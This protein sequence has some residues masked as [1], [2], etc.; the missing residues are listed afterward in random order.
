MDLNVSNTN[1]MISSTTPTRNSLDRIDI[2]VDV[3]PHFGRRQSTWTKLHSALD[4]CC[5]PEAQVDSFGFLER[6]VNAFVRGVGHLFSLG[7]RNHL[8]LSNNGVVDCWRG[9]QIDYMLTKGSRQASVGIETCLIQFPWVGRLQPD[10]SPQRMDRY[11][12]TAAKGCRNI[13]HLQPKKAHRIATVRLTISLSTFLCGLWS[14]LGLLPLF[15]WF[16]WLYV[17]GTI[18][19]DCKQLFR[20]TL[21]PFRL[22]I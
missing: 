20:L 2:S 9:I 16:R 22:G 19:S 8:P 18:V 1:W 17:L 3:S 12:L 15:L 7:W 11:R 10:W 14:M 6:D 21:L 13:C 5:Y 4:S